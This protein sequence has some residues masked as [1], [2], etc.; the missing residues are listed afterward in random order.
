VVV[1]VFFRALGDF[2]DAHGVKSGM[3]PSPCTVIAQNG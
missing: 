2:L 1:C 3:T